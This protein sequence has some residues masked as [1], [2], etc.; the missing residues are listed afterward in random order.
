MTATSAEQ[1]LYSVDRRTK[2]R[3][4]PEQRLVSEIANMGWTRAEQPHGGEGL[5][6]HIFGLSYIWASI[7]QSVRCAKLAHRTDRA[8][9][10]YSLLPP[11]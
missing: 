8:W 3:S 10:D 1:V 9:F 4:Q 2:S 5:Q 11:H 7:V 6:E